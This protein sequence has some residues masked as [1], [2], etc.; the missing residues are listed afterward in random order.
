[1]LH[2]Y[3]DTSAIVKR[4]HQEKG[5]IVIDRIFSSKVKK[6]FATSYW[7]VLEFAV[8]FTAKRERKQISKKA[9]NIAMASFLKE[10]TDLFTIRSVDDDIVAAAIPYAIKHG[11][12][13]ADSLHLATVLELRGFVEEFGVGDRVTF[14]SADSKLCQ[15]AKKE[16]LEIINPREADAPNK[17]G[18]ILKE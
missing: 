1:M 18:K 5:S 3:F 6:S 7:T 8:A 9:F 14:V 10:L 16:N 11:L 13:S 15:A 17:V 2:L 12:A 4:Y